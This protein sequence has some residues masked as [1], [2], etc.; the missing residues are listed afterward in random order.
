MSYDP[1]GYPRPGRQPQDQPP[2]P[3]VMPGSHP[4][5]QP[6]SQPQYPPGP[7]Y[8]Q[9]AKP[10][11]SKAVIALGVALGVVMLCVLGAAFSR[12][13]KSGGPSGGGKAAAMNTPVR[14]GKF[15]FTV[16]DVKCGQKTLGS[17]ILGSTAQGM[18]CLVAVRVTNIGKEAQSFSGSDQK[19]IDVNGAEYSDDASAA[20]SV[21]AGT[22]MWLEQINPGNGVSGTVVFDV[23]P[24]TQPAAIELHDS[25]FSGGV[26]VMLK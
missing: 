23:P 15:E 1:H 10:K 16:T 4:V 8:Q 19:L 26:K 6:Y 14:D 21:N 25:S 17:G 18:Y 5:P 12:G 2:A 24:G 11:H 20:M 13:D 9:P 7:A 3:P 22:R